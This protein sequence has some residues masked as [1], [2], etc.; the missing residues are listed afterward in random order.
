MS[1]KISPNHP[2]RQ[3]FNTLVERTF[4]LS[5]GGYNPEVARYLA[6]LLTDFIHMDQVYRLRDARGR[7]LEEVAEMLM[8]GDFQLNATSF[9]REREVHKHIGDFTLFWSGVYPEMLRLFRSPTH[10]DHLLDYMDQGKSSYYIA[11]TFDHGEY[12]G[13]ARVLRQMSSE[14]EFCVVALNRVR[15]EMDR[16]GHPELNASRY[17]APD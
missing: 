7:R 2:L 13:E 14:F 1:T 5:L 16:L 17:A 3:T 15:E 6:D 12:Q 10:K 9:V 11:S 4:K 8:E